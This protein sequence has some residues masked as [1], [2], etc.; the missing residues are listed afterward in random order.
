MLCQELKATRL[1]LT[2]IGHIDLSAVSILP[3]LETHPIAF[4][5]STPILK[6]AFSRISSPASWRWDVP[7]PPLFSYRHVFLSTSSYLLLELCLSC[8]RSW[9][10]SCRSHSPM[11]GH[12]TSIGLPSDGTSFTDPLA[13][14]NISSQKLAMKS[15]VPESWSLDYHRDLRRAQ[16][17][18]RLKLC[19]FKISKIVWSQLWRFSIRSR[20]R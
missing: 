11:T 9:L 18:L 10:S 14:A 8:K 6:L 3:N 7:V 13:S 17:R 20:L 2:L 1:N 5:F 4:N 16:L 12:Q 15:L 19:P